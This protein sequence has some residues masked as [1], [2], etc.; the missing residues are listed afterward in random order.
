MYVIYT[1]YVVDI[2]ETKHAINSAVG[3]DEAVAEPQD[4]SYSKQDLIN[5]C[6]L[7]VLPFIFLLFSFYFT[8]IFRRSSRRSSSIPVALLLLHKA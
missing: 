4:Y 8:F 2:G 7:L 5:V 1:I 6:V 3:D